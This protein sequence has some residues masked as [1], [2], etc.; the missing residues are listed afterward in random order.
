MYSKMEDWTPP[1]LP[2]LDLDG[3]APLCGV[4]WNWLQQRSHKP[5]RCRFKSGPRNKQHAMNHESEHERRIRQC[6]PLKRKQLSARER[7][8]ILRRD[9]F[10]CRSCGISGVGVQ[11]EIDHVVPLARGGSNAETNYQTLCRACNS[12]KGAS[13]PDTMPN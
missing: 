7:M 8:H 5:N 9:Q 10:T 6:R 3:R 13:M 2:S 12:A 11:L 4:G 1:A